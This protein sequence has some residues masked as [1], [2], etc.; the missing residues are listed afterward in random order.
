MVP[1]MNEKGTTARA[2]H[3]ADGVEDWRVLFSGA[4]AYFRVTSFAEGARFVAAIAEVAEAVGHFPDV[5]LRPEGVTVRTAS[6]EY[7]ALSERDVEL[8]RRISVA[9]VRLQVEPDPSQVQVIGIAVAQDSGSDVGPFWAAAFGYKSLGAE[10]D[11]V[12]RHRRNPH[13]SFQRLRPPRPGRGRTHVECPPSDPVQSPAAGAVAPLISGS[14][15]G[16]LEPSP[17]E[18]AAVQAIVR[19]QQPGVTQSRSQSSDDHRRRHLGTNMRQVLVLAAALMIGAC[20]ATVP[21]SEQPAPSTPNGTPSAETMA[22]PTPT[23]TMSPAATPVPTASLMPDSVLIGMAVAYA[24]DAGFRLADDVPPAFVDEEPAFDPSVLHR[25]SLALADGDGTSLDVYL[26]D[27]GAIRVVADGIYLRS[28]ETMLG[29]AE[30]M[31]AGERHLRQVGVDTTT[32]TLHVAAHAA[33]HW[34]LTFD[35]EIDGYR[36]AN[37]PMVWW[38]DGDK[39]YLELRA[40]GS[41]ANLYAIRPEP[42]AVPVIMDT[43]TLAARLAAVA[44]VSL[45]ALDTYQVEFLWVRANR[46]YPPERTLSL[47]YCATHHFDLGWEAWCID[48]GTGELS[49]TGGGVD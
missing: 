2:F 9:A 48:A 7:G 24:I 35:R 12:D 27:A 28:T 47:G 29:R 45:A 36:V 4:H 40:D 18:R 42:Q 34:Y 41:L 16:A 20:S 46:A 32:G 30:I 49:S 23:P 1:G 43:E 21:G 44:D 3:D 39:A 26:D 15:T 17:D 13:I 5:D 38:L 8:A 6:G 11:V 22:A 31:R 10:E 14:G 37:A 25:V 19:M 33:S